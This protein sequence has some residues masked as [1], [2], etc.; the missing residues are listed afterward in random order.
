MSHYDSVP[1]GPGYVKD[2]YR[3][4]YSL[5]YDHHTAE[6]LVQETFYR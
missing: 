1:A 3:Y 5:S 6:D 2:V 4:L